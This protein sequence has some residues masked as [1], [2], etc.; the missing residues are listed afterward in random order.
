MNLLLQGGSMVN[1]IIPYLGRMP[2]VLHRLDMYTSGE[3]FWLLHDAAYLLVMCLAVCLETRVS[4]Y[5][6]PNR[7]PLGAG[8]AL[9]AAQI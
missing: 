5:I 8:A 6:S 2:H 7:A 3:W 1:R 4:P 9:T